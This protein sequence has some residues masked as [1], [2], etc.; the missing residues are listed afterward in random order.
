MRIRHLT[1]ASERTI[2]KV[3]VES[4]VFQ[5]QKYASAKLN[6]YKQNVDA[7]VT[8][9]RKLLLLYVTTKRCLS[10][11]GVIGLTFF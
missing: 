11:R 4:R 7:V 6:V 2:A 3:Q 10:F 8:M 1:A 5:I 9:V